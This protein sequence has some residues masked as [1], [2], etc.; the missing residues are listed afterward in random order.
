MEKLKLAVEAKAFKKI[1]SI[2]EPHFKEHQP[3][4]SKMY[5]TYRLPRMI[6]KSSGAYGNF[7]KDQIVWTLKFEIKPNMGKNGTSQKIS[8]FAMNQLLL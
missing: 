3:D 7:T 1:I 6:L 8:F 4:M 5:A 2:L